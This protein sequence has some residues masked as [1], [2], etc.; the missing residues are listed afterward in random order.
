LNMRKRWQDLTIT[1]DYMFKLVMNHAR[2][3]KHLLECVLGIK[4]RE[5][6]YLENEKSFK[7][8]YDA[9]GIRIDVYVE[10]ENNSRFIV[11]MQVR[12]YGLPE[13]GRRIRYYNSTIDFD[14][15]TVGTDYDKLGNSAVIVFCPFKLFDGERRLYT[16]KN[17][18]QEDKNIILDDGM[19][20]VLLSSAGKN[21]DDLHPDV[22]AFLDY[23]N[24]KLDNNNFIQDID[25]EIKTLK[26]DGEKEAGYMTFQMRINEERKEAREEGRVE[27][28]E[29]GREKGI[30]EE[31]IKSIKKLMQTLDYPV[32][33]ALEFVEVPKEEWD[34][35]KSML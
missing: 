18:C 27:G 10:D 33:K 20:K 4:I 6:N 26:T 13:L 21:T 11:E 16:F 17:T 14:F 25:A 15:L 3:C 19:I 35:Y 29:E 7:N 31:R 23:M 34:K 1:D 28:R 8:T 24:G 9:K 5:I 22:A 32:E 12:S 2:I 30:E